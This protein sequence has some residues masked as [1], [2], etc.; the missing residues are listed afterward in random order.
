MSPRKKN[1]E[2]SSSEDVTSTSSG[3]EENSKLTP[4][5]YL[6]LD[7]PPTPLFKDSQGGLVIPQVPLF[8]VSYNFYFIICFHNL[9]SDI[10]ENRR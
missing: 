5:L 2:T 9:F 6:S 7:I 1:L 4:F 10:K 3:W 8:E